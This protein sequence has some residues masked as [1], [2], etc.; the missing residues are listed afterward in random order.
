M[1]DAALLTRGK[2]EG[3]AISTGQTISMLGQGIGTPAAPDNRINVAGDDEIVVQVD[4]TGAAVGELGVTVLPY[5]ADGVTIIPSPLP[6]MSSPTTNPVFSGGHVY[7]V[8][9]FD[10]SA[11]EFVRVDIK[12]NNAG[13]QTITRASWRLAGT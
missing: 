11:Q 10:C 7:F 12:N 4:M 9:R 2:M 8:A 6:V 13:G 3:Q 5:A 1:V